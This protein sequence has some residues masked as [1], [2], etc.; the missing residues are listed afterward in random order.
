MSPND[1]VKVLGMPV[2]TQCLYSL[3]PKKIPSLQQPRQPRCELRNTQRH[4]HDARQHCQS[5]RDDALV[6][7]EMAVCLDP[8]VWRCLGLIALLEKLFLPAM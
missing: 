2:S 4:R 8:A 7:L 3:I 6:V 1:N 5:I